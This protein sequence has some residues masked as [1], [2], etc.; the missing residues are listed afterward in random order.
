[1]IVETLCKIAA[2][3][4]TFH[5]WCSARLPMLKSVI[6]HYLIAQLLVIAATFAYVEIGHDKGWP[7]AEVW[8]TCLHTHH[9]FPW[10]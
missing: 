3:L 5:G 10:Q 6:L 4:G 9:H 7:R 2:C 1:M 8:H